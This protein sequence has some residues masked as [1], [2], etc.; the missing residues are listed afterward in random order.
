MRLPGIPTLAFGVLP[1]LGVLAL[2]LAHRHFSGEQRLAVELGEDV[3]PAVTRPA[4][5]VPKQPQLSDAWTNSIGMKLV[6]IP[7]GTFMMGSPADEEHRDDTPGSETQHQVQLTKGFWMGEAEVTRSEFA[8]FILEAQYLTDAV[9]NMGRWPFTWA[10]EFTL[11]GDL[12][13]WEVSTTAVT[14]VSWNDAKAF[15][16]WLSAKEGRGYRL[17]TEAEWEYACRAGTT[18]PFYTGETLIPGKDANFD[19]AYPDRSARGIVSAG[20]YPP[21]PWGLDNMLGN[22]DEW[23]EDWLGPFSSDSVTDP[24]GPRQ[25]LTRVM[26]GGDYGESSFFCR[27]ASRDHSFPDWFHEFVG[28]RV[29]MDPVDE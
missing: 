1:V 27:S 3:I 12:T 16:K 7:P 18:T 5:E 29:V 11:F 24:K 15:C 14:E 28:F 6:Y 4:G 26:R 9:H 10:F 8:A 20:T 25:G 23:C 17:P 19:D 2:V 21:N 22:L 13:D